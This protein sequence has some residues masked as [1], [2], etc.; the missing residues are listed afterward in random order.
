[1]DLYKAEVESVDER[2]GFI[3]RALKQRKLLDHTIIVF[4]SDHGEL[5]WEHGIW[6]HCGSYYKLLVNVPLVFAGPG[7]PRGKR[8]ETIVSHLDLMPTLKELLDVDYA[9][10]VQGKSYAPLF[11][12]EELNNRAIYFD[13]KSNDLKLRPILSDG[14]LMGRY[15]LV[16]RTDKEKKKSSFWLYDLYNDPGETTNISKEKPGIVKQMFNKIRAVRKENRRRLKANL[17]KTGKKVDLEAE[18]EK[19]L[20]ELRTLGY[21]K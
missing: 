4:T 11:E 6:G 5:F 15:K 18:R 21:I 14:L 7:I 10:N 17:A 20:R 8:E 2:V 12:G 9:D 3:I 13:R 16:V 1:M 19:T